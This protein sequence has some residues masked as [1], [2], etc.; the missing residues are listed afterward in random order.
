[1]RVLQWH[2]GPVRA[3]AYSP[4][5]AWLASGGNDHRIRLWRLAGDDKPRMLPGHSDW[6]RGLA[7][8][9]DGK[10][11][12][13]VGWDDEVKLWE[14]KRKAFVSARGG[15]QG[16]AWSLAFSPAGD[17]LVSGAGDGTLSFAQRL[18]DTPRTRRQ[19]RQPVSALA[20]APGGKLLVSASH[21]KTVKLWDGAWW[22]YKRTLQTH[23]DRV[24]SLAASGDGRLV[25]AGNDA[26]VILVSALP[27]GEE[28]VRIEGHAGPADGVAFAEGGRILLSVGWDGMARRWDV[29]SGKEMQAYEWGVGKL[30]CLA[31][32]PDGMT[33][34]AGAE[35]GDVIVWDVEE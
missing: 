20:F 25:A 35:N 17:M 19:H 30:L 27:K 13:S 31:L 9:P 8:S 4:D 16:G 5:G 23:G 21:D 11:L 22:E 1:M 32:A 6:V 18:H 33:A 15:H 3:V 24:R 2:Q 26:G 12:G 10:E 29:L 7:F 34:A 28:V 14:V